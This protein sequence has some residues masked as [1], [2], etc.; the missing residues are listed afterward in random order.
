MPWNFNGDIEIL[1]I[2]SIGL[3]NTVGFS[4]IS[5]FAATSE[6][7]DPK[8]VK[9]NAEDTRYVGSSLSHWDGQMTSFLLVLALSD[10]VW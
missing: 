1:K 8:T 5:L 9:F 10:A 6:E 2:D 7:E 4:G 3:D